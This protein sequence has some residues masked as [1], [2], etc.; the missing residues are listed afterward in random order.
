MRFPLKVSLF[1]IVLVLSGTMAFAAKLEIPILTDSLGWKP[2]KIHWSVLADEVG[3]RTSLRLAESPSLHPSW[4]PKL[5][6]EPLLW[7][8]SPKALLTPSTEELHPGLK[9][10]LEQGG[11]L[12]V[13]G[14]AS[15]LMTL[16]GKAL[17]SEKG[18]QTIALSSELARSFYL[19]DAFSLCYKEASSWQGYTYDNRLAV[20]VIGAPLFRLATET[21]FPKEVCPLGTSQEPFL[22]SLINILMVSLTTD[23]KLDQIHL[24]EILKRL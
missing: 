6:T 4:Q 1:F 21:P 5:L 7:A 15:S 2:Q 17:G 13:E 19:L 10:W 12:V 3:S 18:W 16:I 22:R 24:K 8:L 11:V 20:I 9:T 14:H 23:Y